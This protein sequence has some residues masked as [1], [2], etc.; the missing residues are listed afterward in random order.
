MSNC[1][2]EAA[3]ENILERCRCAPGTDSL[4]LSLSHPSVLH[5][6]WSRS[7]YVRLLLVEDFR[8]LLAAEIKTQ[9]HWGVFSL[10]LMVLYG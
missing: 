1:L 8:V 7:N 9:T 10:L 2:F 3:F 4:S 6:H 5:S